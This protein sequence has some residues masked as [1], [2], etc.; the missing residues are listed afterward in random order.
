M[1]Q[2]EPKKKKRCVTKACYS[3]KESHIKCSHGRPCQPCIDR[4]TP[5]LC[6]DLPRK[7][8]VKGGS[9]GGGSSSTRTEDYLDWR[10]LYENVYT[11]ALQHA[12]TYQPQPQLQQSLSVAQQVQEFLRDPFEVSLVKHPK[13]VLDH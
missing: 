9:K 12:P 1:S 11:L 13:N 5:D 8:R 7:R 3:C 10:L 6:F 4:K 2:E